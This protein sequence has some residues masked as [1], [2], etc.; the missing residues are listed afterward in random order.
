M[1]NN[2]ENKRIII[3]LIDVLKEAR[4][5]QKANEDLEKIMEYEAI[6]VLDDLINDSLDIEERWI[7][8]LWGFKASEIAQETGYTRANISSR[9][10]YQLR[11]KE[12]EVKE[13][14]R[15]NRESLFYAKKWY[16]YVYLSDKD[17]DFRQMAK[18]LPERNRN[19]AYM[20]RMYTTYGG[21]TLEKDFI[22]RRHKITPEKKQRIIEDLKDKTL[23]QVAFQERVQ[24]DNVIRIA[25]DNEVEYVTEKDKGL[26][27]YTKKYYQWLERKKE[28]ELEY[29][30]R[31][32]ESGNKEEDK[33]I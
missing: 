11:G 24:I 9:I 21:Q 12:S 8:Y 10:N 32:R 1:E 13:K 18:Y 27:E 2:K 7:A 25:E 26:D 29:Q 17:G 23:E 14:H 6:K 16:L 22:D 3:P 28:L 33:N 4:L 31:L 15:K 20:Y 19:D 5:D 30:E